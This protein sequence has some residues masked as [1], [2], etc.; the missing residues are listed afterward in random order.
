PDGVVF[1][2]VEHTIPGDSVVTAETELGRFGLSICYDLRFP[3]LYR[4]M[5]LRGTDFVF[6]PS[7]FTS[8]TGKDHWKVLVRARAIEN[9][10]FMLAPNQVGRTATGVEFYGHSMIVDPW[11]EVLAEG[12]ELTE[13]VLAELDTDVLKRVRERVSAL[14]DVRDELLRKPTKGMP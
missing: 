4:T 11:G 1:S 12:A 5:M 14:S 2:E 13:L 3:E 9:Q 7:A 6:A 8:F 10:V